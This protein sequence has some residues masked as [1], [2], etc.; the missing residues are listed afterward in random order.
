M[1]RK[2]NN[3]K[4]KTRPK[5]KDRVDYTARTMAALREFENRAP[6]APKETQN[7]V[8]RVP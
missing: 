3:S 4:N 8:F 1:A 7:V 2:T 6:D 5:R